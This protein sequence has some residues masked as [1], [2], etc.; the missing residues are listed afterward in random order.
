MSRVGITREQGGLWLTMHT[1]DLDI[2]ERPRKVVEHTGEGQLLLS[3][4]DV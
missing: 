3:Y 1:P 2:L 4:L